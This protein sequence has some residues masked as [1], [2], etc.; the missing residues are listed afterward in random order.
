MTVCTPTILTRIGD[1]T[2]F[3]SWK[4]TTSATLN[5]ISTN[6]KAGTT[7]PT[8]TEQATLVTTQSEIFNTVAC[9]QEQITKLGST[10][11]SIQGA[12][13]QILSLQEQIKNEQANADIARDRVAYIRNPEQQTSFYES[14]FPMDRPM[15]LG[16]VPIFMGVI[17][18]LFIFIILIILSLAGANI[19]FQFPPAATTPNSLFQILRSITT[20]EWILMVVIIIFVIYFVNRK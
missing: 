7:E 19:T 14:W 20:L 6:A 10:T 5:S 3:A 17:V 2:A 18:F 11:N 1:S 12:Q 13:Q 16:S 8:T 9:L 4:T 15:R